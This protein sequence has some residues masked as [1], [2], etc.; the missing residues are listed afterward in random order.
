M[1]NKYILID[2]SESNSPKYILEACAFN[3]NNA[4]Y[5]KYLLFFTSANEFFEYI[6]LYEREKRLNTFLEGM[7]FNFNNF[8]ILNNKNGKQVGIILD[9]TK[10][11][12]NIQNA[13]INII[14]QNLILN[15][16]QFLF[17]QFNNQNNNLNNNNFP[18]IQNK[19]IQN[20]PNQNNDK[21]QLIIQNP[22]S[23]PII[24][25]L[26]PV[27]PT[28]V[29]SKPVVKNVITSIVEEFPF[30]PLIGLQNVGATCYMNATLQCF[31]QIKKLVDYFKYNSKIIE[32][33]DYKFKNKSEICLTYSFKYLVENLWP[34]PSGNKY[35]LTKNMNQNSQN[36]YFAPY[37]FKKKISDMNPLF[38]GAQA[39]D[40]KD[41]VNFII[42]TLHEELNKAPKNPNSNINMFQINQTNEKEILDC[43]IKCFMNDNQ[44]IISDIFYGVSKT[45]TQCS[46]CRTIKY[47]FQAYFFLIFPLEEVRKYKIN[48][49]Q[50]QFIQMNQNMNMNQFLFQQNMLNL[51]N[52]QNLNIVNIDDCFN[53]NEKLENFTGENSMYCNICG[54]NLPAFYQ[55]I[56]FT[57]PEILIIVLNRGKG[58]QFKVKLE[59]QEILNLKN[60]IKRQD[61]GYNY[62]LIGVVTHMGESGASGHFIAYCK[63]PISNDWY[64]YNDD[65]VFKVNN[66]KQEI[67]DYAMPYILFYQKID[68]I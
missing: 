36:R 45:G 9:L 11:N 31:C 47:N 21:N 60:Y 6:D 26:I 43:F 7:Q 44:S 41:L 65:L 29:I 30:P 2:V 24:K 63:S 3:N 59:F 32:I 68:T 37:G 56:L 52:I 55:T 54:Q 46:R 16:N 14:N 27:I 25:K 67:I 53:Y 5:P 18:I 17:S 39:N 20:I 57:S 19:I 10:P 23:L 8:I 40:S 13:P 62:K 4:I 51:Q 58:I 34:S 28:Q 64:Q 49:L 12:Q 42:M 1:I 50:N 48:Q 35:I 61:T 66:F 15:N 22:K 38:Q 33:I